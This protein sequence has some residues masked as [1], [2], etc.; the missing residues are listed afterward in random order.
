MTDKASTPATGTEAPAAQH[1]PSAF[2]G[3]MAE[4]EYPEESPEEKKEAPA[5]EDEDEEEGSETT[6]TETEEGDEETDE[7][8]A[9]DEEATDESTDGQPQSFTVKIDGKNETVT[10]DELKKG[11]SRTKVFTQKTQEAAE[12]RKAAEADR[13]A[14]AAEREQLAKAIEAVNAQMTEM[15]PEPDWEALKDDREEYLFQKAIWAEKKERRDKLAAVK[16]EMER[17]NGEDRKAA[18]ASTLRDEHV[19]L[20]EKVPAWKD[21]KKAQKELAEIRKHAS[22]LGFPD[23]VLDTITDHRIVLMLRNSMR[24]ERLMANKDALPVKTGEPKKI[25]KSPKVLKPGSTK[26]GPVI[27]ERRRAAMDELRRTGSKEVARDLLSMIP[28]VTD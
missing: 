14:I 17:R 4:L 1:D 11:Y 27:A 18:M 3:K 7:E 9:E 20:L 25:D 24:Y 23:D 21:E 5:P 8:E 12:V 16:A 19:K 2:F 10:L 6:A 13:A 15:D 26:S 28:G 22:D